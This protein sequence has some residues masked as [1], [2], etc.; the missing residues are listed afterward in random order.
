MTTKEHKQVQPQIPFGND[1]QN[2]ETTTALGLGEAGVEE[3][4]VVAFHAGDG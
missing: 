1:K 2:D 3:V 4:L